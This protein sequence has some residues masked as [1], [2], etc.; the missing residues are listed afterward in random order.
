MSSTALYVQ[1]VGDG[2]PVVLLHG[3]GASSRYW[4]GVMAATT[5]LAVTAPDLLGFGRSP[6]PRTSH[7]DVAAHVAAVAP[8]VPTGS[9]VVGHSAGAILAAALAAAYPERVKALVLVGLPAFPDRQTAERD[10]GRLGLLPRWTVEGRVVGRVV[11]EAMCRVRPLM[12]AAAPLLIRDLP[13]AIAED[14]ARHTWRSFEGT[15]RGVVV[16]HRTLPDLAAAPCPTVMLHG[17]GDRD[18]PLEHVDALAVHARGAGLAL[19]LRVVEGDHHLAVHHP[20][21]VASTIAE[22]EALSDEQGRATNG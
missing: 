1:R 5:D 4:A 15:L 8:L 10:V 2:P 17:R 21:L 12:V 11:C 6:K 19:E 20:Q 14:G 9:V 16:E 22:L 3:L 18:A 13:R 7:Y